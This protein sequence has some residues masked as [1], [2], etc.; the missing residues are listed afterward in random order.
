MKSHAIKA[1]ALVSLLALSPAAQAQTPAAQGRTGAP[2][3]D[4]RASTPADQLPSD[5]IDKDTGHRVRRIS[6]ENGSSSNY[7]NV[8]SYTPDGKWM[9]YSSPSGIMV[10]DLKTFQ[11]KLAVPSTPAAPASLQFVGHKTGLI[12]YT[13]ALVATQGH[14]AQPQGAAAAQ[15]NRN[16]GP[17]AILSY[18]IETGETKQI[19]ELD[20]GYRIATI[21]ADETLF[22]GSRETGAP[23]VGGGQALGGPNG[24]GNA[25]PA[26]EILPNGQRATYAEGREIQ[27]NRRLVQKIPMEIFTINIKTGEKKTITAST[28]WLN[29]LQFSPTD[30]GLLL[31]C[32]EGNWHIV[33]RLWL[34]R[35]DRPDTPRN[36]HVRTMNMEIA[37]HEWWSADG[38]TV[39][40]DLQT[41]RGEVFW[42]AGYNVETGKR[43]QYALER[44]AWGVHF[45]T[46]RDD[47]LFVSDGGDNEMAAHAP[48]GKYI[49]LL[50]PRDIPDVAGISAPNADKLI[51]PGV[52]DAERLVNLNPHNY[53]SEP[54]A[55]FTPD[56]KWIVF[57]SNMHGP[58]HVYAV[59]VAK[60]AAR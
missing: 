14:D 1:L 44:N 29:H 28:D 25:D 43:T 7:F 16:R 4:P 37:G 52:L 42:V 13:G 6:T 31:Y 47:K 58:G 24:G 5:W 46:S 40:Y 2:P 36:I 19:A 30:P 9:A 54:N 20:A 27:I 59:E 35:V 18:N 15:A 11:S 51:K 26:S 41:P 57:R 22:A 48:D 55:S 56:G 21:N 45:N 33:D 23:T 49:Q 12:Y 8:N 50:R 60:S 32:H 17:R 38:K 3:P 53:R 10:M 39:W 34:V